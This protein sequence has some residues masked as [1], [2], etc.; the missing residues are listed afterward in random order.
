MKYAKNYHI[1][2]FDCEGH[3]PWHTLR[4]TFAA[5]TFSLFLDG[6]FESS[7]VPEGAEEEDNNVSLILDWTNL[8]K[9]PKRS[10]WKKD[11]HHYRA[12]AV[13]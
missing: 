1:A 10:S 2:I 3:D 9:K 6:L 8:K 7:D 11:D 12:K 13:V 4:S 5:L